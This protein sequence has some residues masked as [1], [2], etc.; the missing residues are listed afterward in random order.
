MAFPGVTL[1]SEIV[2]TGAA[3]WN[4]RPALADPNEA[5]N[6]AELADQLLRLARGF[7]QLGVAPGDRVSLVLPNS[8][9]LLRGHFAALAAGAVSVPCDAQIT[10]SGYAAIA[11]SCRPRVLVTDSA[12]L[13]RLSLAVVGSTV[14]RVVLFGKATDGA[15]DGAAVHSAEELMATK[16]LAAPVGRSPDDLAALMY[17]TGTT[18][19]PKGVKLTHRNALTALRNICEFVGYTPDDRE[20]VIL[21]LSHNFGLGHVYCN[22]LSGGAVYTENGLTRVGRVLKTI[23]E[24]GATGFPG[25]PLG[26]GMLIDKFGPVL[27]QRCRKLRF[28]VI[29]SAPLPPERTVQLQELLPTL[30]IMVYYGLTEASRSCFASLT[31]LGPAKYRSVGRPMRGV[32]IKLR[33][34]D[35]EIADGSGEVLISGPTVTSG[36]WEDDEATQA[37]F[38]DG[39]LHTGDLGRFDEDGNLSITGRIKDFI[40]VGGY[41]V[42]PTEVEQAI[43]GFP[44]VESVGVAGVEGLDGFTGETVVAG[45]V[46]AAGA[47]VDLVAL[48]KHCLASLE[49]FKVPGHFALI[50][51]V[52]RSD[53]GKTKR[54]ELAKRLAEVVGTLRVP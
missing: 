36:Y 11:G 1:L 8:V 45:I 32:Q 27:A 18:G 30:D 14:E 6:Y 43:A 7:T 21:P 5:V 17:T 13:E 15:A 31:Q 42:N 34:V 39:W 48:E 50:E 28:T 3:R 9:N 38:Q 29:N 25:T 16:P 20:V 49:K 46:A 2:T 44:G 40:N 54:Q 23:D 41:K 19:R 33:P 22:L 35:R 37:V 4:D 51:Q 53:T 12:S 26:F 24:W 52:P 47:S 10:A